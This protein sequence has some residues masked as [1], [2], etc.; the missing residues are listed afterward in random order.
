VFCSSCSSN[1]NKIIF[2][3]SGK[4]NFF[5]FDSLLVDSDK[6]IFKEYK[7]K[8]AEIAYQSGKASLF[9]IDFNK[10]D[11][12]NDAEDIIV[13]RDYYVKKPKSFSIKNTIKTDKYY[14]INKSVFR[15][16]NIVFQNDNYIADYTK[17]DND[18]NFVDR[19]NR[20]I[21]KIP[22]IVFYTLDGNKYNLIDFEGLTDY[23]Y[24]DFWISSCSPCI[25]EIPTLGEI[26]SK[27]ANKVKVISINSDKL[28]KN[29]NLVRN[30]VNKND[31][32]WIQG[33]SN[34]EMKKNIDFGLYPKGYLFDKNG[35]LISSSMTPSQFLN[36][37]KN[38]K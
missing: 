25:Q 12:Y 28:N 27:F 7:F 26:N 2:L 22:D 24:I 17:T 9:L 33:V 30:I 6:V 36:L 14:S 1:D 11:I 20:V 16:E 38:H 31:M 19:N 21:D 10:N 18:I 32:I 37:L 13:I 5:D 8:R 3:E 34:R 35:K 23:I 4:L 29:E 15:I